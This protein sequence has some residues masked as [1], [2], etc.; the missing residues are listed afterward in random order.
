MTSDTRKKKKQ[1]SLYKKKLY[2]RRWYV[3]YCL[4]SKYVALFTYYEF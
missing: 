2:E 4:G 3:N 1:S